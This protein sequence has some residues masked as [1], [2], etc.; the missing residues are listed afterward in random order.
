MLSTRAGIRAI[1]FWTKEMLVRRHEYEIK[2]GG[3][4][5]GKLI[6]ISVGVVEAGMDV[7]D[8]TFADTREVVD[9]VEKWVD[10]LAAL[11]VKIETHLGARLAEDPNKKGLQWLKRRY[12]EVLDKLPIWP[13]EGLDSFEEGQMFK[14]T[15]TSCQCTLDARAGIAKHPHTFIYGILI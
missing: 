3:F 12:N 14:R 11:R 9:C 2:N 15:S 1:Q 5:C 10:K 13:A 4:G 6:G 7:D 8:E